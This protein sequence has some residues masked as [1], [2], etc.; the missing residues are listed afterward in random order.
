MTNSDRPTLLSWKLTLFPDCWL[1]FLGILIVFLTLNACAPKPVKPPPVI[2][3]VPPTTY[4]METGDNLF[5][6]AEHLFNEKWYPNA[7]ELY[8]EYLTQFPAG[9]FA[10]KALM[11]SAGIYMAMEAY[12]KARLAYEGLIKKYP[13]SPLVA[14]AEID[15]VFAY[16]HE[17]KYENA[18]AQA[19]GIKL[20]ALTP[21]TTAVI[22]QMVGDSFMALQVP[23]DA[24]RFY[25]MA[26]HLSI[27]A[28]RAK[29]LAQIKTAIGKLDT[30]G[31]L[32]LLDHLA[33]KPPAG[34]L[35][36][37]LAIN[38]IEEQNYDAAIAILSAFIENY[39]DH[40]YR[41]QA[42]AR[43]EELIKKY[44][45]NRNAIGCLLP[46]SGSYNLY[47]Q[48]TLSAIQFALVHYTRQ[49]QNSD[50][51]LI[52]KDT[53]SD[54]DRTVQA[55]RE[56]ADENVAAIIGPLTTIEPAALEAQNREIPIITLT[57]KD[58]IVDIGDFVFR[59]FLTPR[60]QVQ[61]L[62]SYAVQQLG[63][64]RFAILYPDESYG[65]TFMNLFW[66]EVIANGCTITGIEAYRPDQTD[67]DDPIN[68]L[69]GSY[70]EI[71]ESLR[72]PIEF[73][74]EVFS[75]P[76]D[77]QKSQVSSRGKRTSRPE[78]PPAVIDFE[79]I[80]IPDSPK[81]A[82]LLVPQLAFHDVNDVYLL[83]TNLWNQPE[84]I[85]M[86]HEYI[87]RAVIP[88]AFFLGGKSE[89]VRSFTAEFQK[90]FGSSPGFIEA[91]AYDTAS[92][93]FELTNR[94]DILSRNALKNALLTL[95]DYPG[96][97]GATSFEPSGDVLK[98]LSLLGVRGK[99]F[100][101]L[102]KP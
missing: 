69:V 89:N 70:Y 63:I 31:I 30:A 27:P 7:L 80:F 47:G 100:I 16:Y 13:Q 42:Q 6:K 67:F 50:V 5:E 46:L 33:G 39:R 68:K 65:K 55:V 87:Q 20:E 37:Q 43:L 36:Y 61:A 2:E 91:I 51:R 73:Q 1:A 21:E 78:K 54:P 90:T 48:R 17:G 102:K 81:K 75:R 72:D 18:I 71:P 26:Y 4:P 74:A 25:A 82:G 101:E 32:K 84:M 15:L 53:G 44:E 99:Q 64:Q 22:S 35:M 59:N 98:Q 83:G 56:L 3:R 93:L 40:E 86:A 49:T 41:S 38:K 57:Q 24:V 9:P 29:L 23:V 95:K 92:I 77:S 10:D 8:N 85:Q 28:Q 76:V 60:M 34:Y 12:E 58:H 88:T 11:R 14:Q 94:K 96:V 97:T 52:I 62:V 79:A 66:D 19:S 45:F